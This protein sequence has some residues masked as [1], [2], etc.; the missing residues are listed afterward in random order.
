L[1]GLT[2]ILLILLI[3]VVLFFLPRMVSRPASPLRKFPAQPLLKKMSGRWR[4][5]I[6]ASVIW[7]AAMTLWLQPWRG[8]QTLFVGDRCGP[9]RCRLGRLVGRIRLQAKTALGPGRSIS[10]QIILIDQIQYAGP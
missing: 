8:N 7:L 4:L 3:V 6:L 5:A 10:A 2:E 1:S 9:G